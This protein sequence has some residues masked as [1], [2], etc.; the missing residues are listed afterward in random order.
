GMN[1]GGQ[2]DLPW[3][4]AKMVPA[5]HSSA[6]PDGS[7]GGE[8]AGFVLTVD[9]VKVYFACDTALFSDMQLIGQMGINLAVL[10]I[11]DLFTMGPED[12]VAAASLINA[13]QVL[14]TH[15]NTWPPIEQDA[16]A[17][18]ER[19]RSSTSSTPVVLEPGQTHNL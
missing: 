18:A 12:S 7:Y 2:I 3:G 14:P 16:N 1:I 15:Y 17:W 5:I 6:L 4:S 10:P 11:G 9:E 8:P 19:I 13:N